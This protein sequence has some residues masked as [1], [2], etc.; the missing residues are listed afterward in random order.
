M[1]AGTAALAS[2]LVR[3]TIKPPAGAGP[4]RE[5]VLVPVTPEPPSTEGGDRFTLEMETL[6]S[7][8]TV[9]VAVTVTPL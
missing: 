6:E 5:I 2:L 9:R 8:V 4:L 1:E 3:F 7:G